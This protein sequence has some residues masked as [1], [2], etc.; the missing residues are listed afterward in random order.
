MRLHP[1]RKPSRK[2]E[3]HCGNIFPEETKKQRGY[4]Q[5]KGKILVY[6]LTY[7]IMGESNSTAP[8]SSHGATSEQFHH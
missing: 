8:L 2:K 1:E 7:R 3:T 5:T 4:Q 6:A